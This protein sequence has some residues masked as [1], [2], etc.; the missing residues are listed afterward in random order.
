[1]MIVRMTH[2]RRSLFLT[3]F[4]LA[5][6]FLSVAPAQ[7]QST[8]HVW[9]YLNQRTPTSLSPEQ[10]G[11]TPRAMKRRAK[12]LPADKLIDK[13]DYPIPQSVI[14]QIRATGAK[15]RTVSRWLNAVSVEATDQQVRMISSIPRVASTA[16]VYDLVFREPQAASSPSAEHASRLRKG[17]GLDYGPSYDQL[18]NI[19]IIAL[20]DLGING[21]GVLLGMLDDGFNNH[22]THV[23]L[24]N[25]HVV[26]EYDFVQQDSNTSLA[27]GEFFDEGIHGAGTLSSIA[28]FDN[29]TLIGGAF[30]VSV[31]LAKTEVDSV[32][33]HAEEDNYVAGLEWMERLGADI[34]SSSLGYR[35]FDTTTYSY[36]YLQLDG[37]TAIVSRA[38]TIAAQKGL[39]LVTAMGN[40]GFQEGRDSF[41]PGTIVTPAD[42]DSIVSVGA[43][44]LDGTFLASFSGT[45]PTADGR[46]KPEVVAPGENVFW[47]YGGISST[48][49]FWY[50][51][52]TSAATPLT[53]SAAALVL[54][55]H[56]ELTPMQVRQALMSTAVPLSATYPSL[57]VPNDFYGYGL[58]NAFNAALVNGLVFSNRPIITARDSLYII[59][60]WIASKSSLVGNSLAFYYRY[61]GDSQFT[62]V[63]LFA[64]LDPNEY[65]AIISSPPS[66]ITP[67]GYLSAEDASGT[68][69]SPYDA[70]DSLFAI[71]PTSD[72][73]RQFYPTVDN[74]LSPD[75]IPT[76]YTLAHNFPNP[77]N[78]TTTIQFFAPSLD[79]VELV[80]FNV[81]GQRVRTLFSG[82]PLAD[83]N[84]VRWIDA[85]DDNG[86]PVSSGI[87]FARLKTPR[88][89]LTL[90]MV[91]VK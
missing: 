11:I 84:A 86:H 57:S 28:G 4:V 8:R 22:T 74:V 52:G 1:M 66:G 40:E 5:S 34:A 67:V 83:W 81:L 32:E 61:P 82:T 37:H 9:I 68:R 14:D 76:D 2:A 19:N 36:T 88:S 54:S 27:P 39:L 48:D 16:A 46:T 23:A 69:T 12:V 85:Q 30:G 13:Y 15:I 55:A 65:N 72:S 51:Q 58:V 75:Y 73:L 7:A 87:Y 50:V 26:A 53:A 3:F 59:T 79:K 63:A 56:P 49:D 77:F 91:Y 31:I 17:T 35:D 47:A 6:S 38:A 64:G 29:G 71:E 80:V 42:A 21:S 90:K 60:T 24:K 89:V 62:R 10:L 18:N 20:H 70:P 44:S 43:T 25:I 78:P 41:A 33:I 45:G